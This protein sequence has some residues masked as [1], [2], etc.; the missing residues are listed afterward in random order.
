M[1]NS[2]LMEVQLTGA[3]AIFM[4]GADDEAAV[5]ENVDVEVVLDD[6]SR[7][8]ATLI[9]LAEIEHIMNRLKEAGECFDG[10]YFQCADLV[11]VERGGVKAATDLLSQFVVTGQIREAFVRLDI[12]E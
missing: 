8:S 9:T 10:A 1:A 12:E 11:I 3:V 7:W 6:G 2:P 5:I 4:L